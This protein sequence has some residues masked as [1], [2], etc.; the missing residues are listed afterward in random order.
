MEMGF[1]CFALCKDNNTTISI[2]DRVTYLRS[3]PP[4][5]NNPTP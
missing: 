4:I 5:L 2:K 3:V 1:D